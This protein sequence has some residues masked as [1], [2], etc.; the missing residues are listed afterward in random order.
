MTVGTCSYNG[1]GVPLNGESE[2]KQ[3]T[4]GTD[5]ITITGVASQTG[6]FLVCRNSA[7]TEK[8]SVDVNGN[9]TLAG[10]LAFKDN[11]TVAPTTATL[12]DNGVAIYTA[13]GT[14][15]LAVNHDTTIWYF[16]RTGNL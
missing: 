9:L 3:V 16:N 1:Q 10:N 13:G 6:D 15:R 11:G 14:V 5:V 12:P 2:V 4:L 7:G 8:M